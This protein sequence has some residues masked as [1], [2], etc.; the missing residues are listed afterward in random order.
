M[1][2]FSFRSVSRGMMGSQSFPWHR[3]P[4]AVAQNDDVA[5]HG[6]RRGSDRIDLR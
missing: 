4:A 1:S 3:D 2:S 5:A 6:L